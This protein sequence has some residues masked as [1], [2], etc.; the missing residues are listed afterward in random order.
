MDEDHDLHVL[1][2]SIPKQMGGAGVLIVETNGTTKLSYPTGVVA[3]SIEPEV[4]A[5]QKAFAHILSLHVEYGVCVLWFSDSKSCVDNLQGNW[6]KHGEGMMELWNTMQE[7][8]KSKVSIEVV[9]VP[10]HSGLQENERADRLANAVANRSSPVQQQNIPVTADSFKQIVLKKTQPK[11][12]Q[13]LSNV[14]RHLH[15]Q[16]RQAEVLL[17]RLLAACSNRVRA[18]H[19][20]MTMDHTFVKC[21]LKV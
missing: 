14:P 4:L 2:R 6:M 11:T 8:L 3:S 13:R 18:F 15:I 1:H 19:D 17:N 9:W 10:S 12:M 5:A 16:P 20:G 7:I 21:P